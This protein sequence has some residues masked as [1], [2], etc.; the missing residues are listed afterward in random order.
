MIGFFYKSNY[1]HNLFLKCSFGIFQLL[2]K[3]NC[4]NYLFS[5]KKFEAM[6]K[7]K[8]IYSS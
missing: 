4:K 3:V 1:Q 2:I 6:L 5:F 8:I 7:Q